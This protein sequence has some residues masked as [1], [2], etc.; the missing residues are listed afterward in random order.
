MAG[1]SW[2][3]TRQVVTPIR[4]ARQVAERIASGRLEERVEVTGQDDI[5]R[6]GVSFNQMADELQRQIRQLEELSRFQQQF[7]SDVSHELRT[8]LTTVRMAGDVLHDERERFDPMTARAAELLQAE[9]DRFENLLA[10]LLEVSRFDAGAAVLDLDEVDL[11]AVVRRVVEATSPLA[12]RR[13]VRVLGA[14][15]GRLRGRGRRTPGRADRAQPAHQR[16]RPRTRQRDRDPT[17]RP[18]TTPRRLSVRDHGVGLRPGD[19]DRVFNR[20]WRADPARARTTGGTGLGLAISLEDARLHGGDLQ[21]WGRPGEGALFLLTLPRRAGESVSDQ[22]APARADRH[23]LGGARG[24]R[25]TSGPGSPGRDRAARDGA[26][27]SA[28]SGCWSLA[29]GAGAA[30]SAACSALPESGPVHRDGDTDSQ[31]GVDSAR[32]TAPGPGQG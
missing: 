5:A 9:L 20:F 8:P 4:L 12:D 7:V 19:S 31:V 32:F 24:A 14:R 22:P 11:E 18:T 3:V 27:M 26:P 28:A 6:L 13:G 30:C 1:L 23:R 29:P 10:D 15:R 2:L 25:P 17:G 16:D 21:A